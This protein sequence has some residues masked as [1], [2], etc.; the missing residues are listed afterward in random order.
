RTALQ[1]RTDLQVTRNTMASNNV[2]LKS[3]NDQKLPAVDL[4]TTY[5]GA[6]L[7]GTSILFDKPSGLDR[8]KTG[9]IPGGY[10]DALRS[11]FGRKYPNWTMQ[12]NVSYPIGGGSADANAARTK[13]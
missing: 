10:T 6:G 13:L 5:G 8:V 12:V 4:T 1:Q 3:F 11:L 9:E 7:G 2:V